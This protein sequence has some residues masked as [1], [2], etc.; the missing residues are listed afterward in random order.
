VSGQQLRI[1]RSD[2][3]PDAA[4][5]APRGGKREFGAKRDFGGDKRDF[6]RK[7]PGGKS[8]AE[9]ERP[10]RAFPKHDGKPPRK[11]R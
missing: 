3:A 10:H 4:D 6:V 1:T 2:E 5:H 7:K 8:N 9:G 11:P